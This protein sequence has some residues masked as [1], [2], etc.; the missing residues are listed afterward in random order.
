MLYVVHSQA[1]NIRFPKNKAIE[2]NLH[3]KA[4]SYLWGNIAWN[5]HCS[6][7][8]DM[9]SALRSAL[10]TRVDGSIAKKMHIIY[11][12]YPPKLDPEEGR[13]EPLHGIADGLASIPAVVESDFVATSITRTGASND[14]SSRMSRFLQIFSDLTNIRRLRQLTNKRTLDTRQVHFANV[15]CAVYRRSNYL[16]PSKYLNFRFTASSSTALI[17]LS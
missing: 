13:T 5:Q 6:L 10:T 8:R 4:Q 1:C 9:S 15:R 3:D 7:D 11:H 2:G 14:Q 12:L 16:P 17:S